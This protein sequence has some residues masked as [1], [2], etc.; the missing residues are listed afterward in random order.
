MPAA[1]GLR[2]IISG[3]GITDGSAGTFGHPGEGRGYREI[4][5]VTTSGNGKIVFRFNALHGTN[6]TLFVG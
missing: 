5:S 1:G 3:R 2:A 6:F 4:F